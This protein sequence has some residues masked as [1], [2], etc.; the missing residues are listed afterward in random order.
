MSRFSLVF[1]AL[2]AVA[3]FSLYARDS[4][5]HIVFDNQVKDFGEV[6]EGETLR[7][8]FRFTNKGTATLEIVSVEPS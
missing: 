3:F 1:F 5:P 2:P 7:H 8:V 6:T 4:A